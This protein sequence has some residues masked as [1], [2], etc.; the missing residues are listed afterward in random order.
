MSGEDVGLPR[1]P[2][3]LRPLL[4]RFVLRRVLESRGFGRPVKTFRPFEPANPPASPA[5]G[6]TRLMGAVSGF[7]KQVR[8]LTPIGDYVFDH[9]AFGKLHVSDYVR[10]QEIHT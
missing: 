5:L 9:P 1:V 7:E 10:F 6:R 4:R 3:L 2:R 8:S